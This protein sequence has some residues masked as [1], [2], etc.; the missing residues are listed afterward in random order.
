[1]DF[2]L[3]PF[4]M[5]DIASLVKHA[6]NIRIAK[7]MSDEF[8]HPYTA[9]DASRFV[10]FA[11]RDDPNHIF[12]IQVDGQAVGGIGIHPQT[13]I[14]RKNVEMGYWLG[15]EFWGHGIMTDAIKQVTLFAFNTYEIN[16]IFARPFG[17]NTA[18]QKVLEKSGFI[19]EA[20]FEKSLF[21]HGEY[22]DELIYAI[23]R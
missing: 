17:T 5:K 23:R 12:A 22:L 3:Q 16:R 1:M 9:E 10:G 2:N 7:F 13:G 21:K 15:E 6:N 11:T 19:L 4:S 8:P 18:S 14:H 20:K